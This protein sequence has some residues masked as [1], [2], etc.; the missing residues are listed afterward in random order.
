VK[1]A[2]LDAGETPFVRRTLAEHFWLVTGRPTSADAQAI[3]DAQAHPELGVLARD[4]APGAEG[5]A[6]FV[7]HLGRARGRGDLVAYG[8]TAYAL[9]G[10]GRSAPGLRFQ[11]EPDVF[12]VLRATFGP[13][14]TDVARLFADFALAR[15]SVGS[16][17]TSGAFPELAWVGDFGRPRFEWSVPWS[18]LPRKLVPSRPVA[19]LGTTYV[20][21]DVD[22]PVG[23]S[24]FVLQ[25]EWE[26]PVAFQWV[27]AVIGAQGETLRRIDVPFLE[28]GTTVE[29]TVTNLDGARGL[30]LAGTNLGGI[31]PSYPFD[32]DFEPFE[33]HS[34]SVYLARQ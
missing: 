31:G 13:K 18:S 27:I 7:E 5:S 16:R 14:P 1:A 22:A 3:D 34:Y 24:T 4:L 25:A 2:A 21:I 33:P 11:N 26:E 30:L 20:W 23:T 17:D 10:W 12:D 15:A 32:P 28:R 19:P 9:S 29:R 6:L 8:A